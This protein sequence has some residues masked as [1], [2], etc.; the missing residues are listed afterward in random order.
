MDEVPL[1]D[2]SAVKWP[3]SLGPQSEPYKRHLF[4]ECP[5]EDIRQ[6]AQAA[7]VIA[8]N[9]R[10]NGS[11]A[12]MSLGRGHLRAANR[13]LMGRNGYSAA[14]FTFTKIAKGLPIQSNQRF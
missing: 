6:Q 7:Q 1:V 8:E 9:A 13:V 4:I 14:G 11:N 5:A 2:L 3:P 10:R 12:T